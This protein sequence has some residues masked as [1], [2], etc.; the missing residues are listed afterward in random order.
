MNKSTSISTTFPLELSFRPVLNRGFM[1]I[2]AFGT[3]L[4][5]FI[6]LILQINAYTKETYLIQE[7][8]SRLSQLVQESKSLEINFSK[9]NSLNNIS[10]HLNGQ[11][12]EKVGQIDYIKVLGGTA[13][14]K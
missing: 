6:I 9:A 12:F 7:Y 1:F 2:L 13:L 3:L 5:L 11:A 10:Y 4:S 14:A 8:E